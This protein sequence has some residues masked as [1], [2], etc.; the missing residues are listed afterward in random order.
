MKKIELSALFLEE[1]LDL[2]QCPVCQQAFEA[3][4]GTSLNCVANHQFDLSKK[5]TLHL[6]M[7]GGQN[8]YDKDMLTSRKNLAA[9]GFFHPML[10]VVKEKLESRS[11]EAVLDVGCGEGSHLHYLNQQG[12][13]GAKIGFDISKDAIQ[14]AAS[15][16][17]DDGFFCVADLA[18]SPFAKTQF[19]AIINILSPSHYEEFDRLLKPGGLVVK[20]VPDS[21]Y[22]IELRQRLYG[23]DDDKQHYENDLVINRFKEAYPDCLHDHVTYEV[24]VTKEAF[25]WLVD[26]TPLTWHITEDKRQALL[27]NPL[28]SMTV[29]M[30]IL[31]GQKKA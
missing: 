17:F 4:I 22:L 14:L 6:L 25:S 24:P 10:D 8:D 20:V 16:F 30:S 11:I 28:E 23:A 18:Q 29:S 1:H 7:K 26:M 3:V 15:H 9:T 27:K 19:D 21:D 13:S 2:F 5:G 12:L 31:V